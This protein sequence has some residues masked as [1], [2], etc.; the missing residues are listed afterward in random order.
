MGLG[1][2]GDSQDRGVHVVPETPGQVHSDWCACHGA[3]RHNH[4]ASQRVLHQ[5][6]AGWK[7]SCDVRD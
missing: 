3:Q 1:Q 2:S 4:G 7:H 6:A 5:Q